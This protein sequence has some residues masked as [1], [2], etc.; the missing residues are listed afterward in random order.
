MEEFAAHV[1]VS[2]VM[3]VY[4]EEKII[5]SAI[6]ETYRTMKNSSYTFQIVAV[7][8]GSSDSSFEELQKLEEFVTI[9]HYKP[10]RGKGY[11]LKQGAK[12]SYGERIVF[13]DSDLNIRPTFLLEYLKYSFE[14]NADVVI[15]SKRLRGAEVSNSLQRKMM[16]V[17]FHLFAKILLGITVMD[18]QVGLKVL[19]KDVFERLLPNLTI[20]RYAFDVELLSLCGFMGFNITELPISMKIEENNSSVDMRAIQKMFVD[21]FR[22]YYRHS[23]NKVIRK[24]FESKIKTNREDYPDML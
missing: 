5:R 23:K 9:E 3:P 11:A 1:D 8:D 7:D 12:K 24:I 21:T 19:K 2:I 13:Y 18:S 4:N 20:N 14:N 22:V 6:L 10:N 17:L 16:S 15:G